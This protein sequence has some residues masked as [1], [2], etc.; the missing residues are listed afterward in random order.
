MADRMRAFGTSTQWNQACD[1]V[2][3]ALAGT[4]MQPEL[5]QTTEASV[6]LDRMHEGT[7]RM[8]AW[9]IRLERW[10]VV[11][12]SRAIAHMA[13]G[14]LHRRVTGSKLPCF[15]LAKNT[16]LENS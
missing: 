14:T 8:P 5:L 2:P 4:L 13:H 10:L 3:S 6:S 7:V 1:G 15:F 9:L 11:E 16:S 12:N